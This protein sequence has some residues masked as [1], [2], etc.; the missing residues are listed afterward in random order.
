MSE[1]VPSVKRV[2][3]AVPTAKGD[4]KRAKEFVKENRWDEALAEYEALIRA[5][6]TSF[7]AQMGA[8]KVKFRQKDYE[9]ALAHFKHALRIDPLKAKPYLSM[10]R[11]YGTLKE[12]DK[13]FE[14]LQNVVRL[15]P[16]SAVAYAGMG[17]ILIIQ[18]KFED[19]ATSLTKA[20]ALNPQFLR[21]Y[22]QLATAY[23]RLGKFPEAIAQLKIALR[24]NSQNA[25]SY[26]GLG[27]VYLEQKDYSNACEAYQRSIELNPE[28]SP[29]TKMRYVEVLI[30][31]SRLEEA[32]N[33]LSEMPSKEQLGS[34]I[35]ILWGDLYQRQGLFKEAAQEYKAAELLASKDDEVNLEEELNNLDILGDDDDW[36][37]QSNKY[38]ASATAKTNLR[39]QRSASD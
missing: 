18:E 39:R 27:R 4:L 7:P 13:A 9:N 19:A 11:I 21:A 38:R 33:V 12:P 6:L 23:A 14:Q 37:D 25:D 36:E 28:A 24:I 17:Q 1:F 34:K 26:A 32:N 30:A 5:D 35:H 16:K 20:I 15:N 31:E 22:Q 10:A 3:S 2:S 29:S 8:G